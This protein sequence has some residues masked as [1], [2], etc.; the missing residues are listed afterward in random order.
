MSIFL[1]KFLSFITLLILTTTIFA[2]EPRTDRDRLWK[3]ANE[4][5]AKNNDVRQS[6]LITDANFVVLR[7]LKGGVSH[8]LTVPMA[9]VTGVDD[10]QLLQEGVRNYFY[11]AWKKRDVLSQLNTRYV[12][13]EYHAFSVNSAYVRSQDQLHI[14]D[15]C[16]KKEIY[17]ILEQQRDA[18]SYEWQPLQGTILGQ[19][20]LAKKVRVTDIRKASPFKL[21]NAY[22]NENK[23]GF[24]P[25]YGIAMTAA[26]NGE[27][28]YLASRGRVPM[29]AIQDED[30]TMTH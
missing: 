16:L 30:C 1:K 18:I 22:I 21:L 29:E 2:G 28:I 15:S 25:Q 7:A 9:R 6:C 26:K 5:C 20:Y 14:H 17:E 24:M 13:D 3:V 12:P 27:I 23:L 11:D 8:T 19:K 4:D 10:A